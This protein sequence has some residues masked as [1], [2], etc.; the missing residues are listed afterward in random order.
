M[1]G[2]NHQ[3]SE[4]RPLAQ[5]GISK[6]AAVHGG[7]GIYLRKPPCVD[8]EA[9]AAAPNA[10]YPI[11]LTPKTHLDRW[12]PISRFLPTKM[13]LGLFTHMESKRPK[14]GRARR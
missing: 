2:G 10:S 8:P 5:R 4:R 14:D 1:R 3:F 7:R 12:I 11:I 9:G 13:L 6:L